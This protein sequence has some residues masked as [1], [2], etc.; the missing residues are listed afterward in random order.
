MMLLPLLHMQDVVH[1]LLYHAVAV[2]AA[3][4]RL[5]TAQHLFFL[6]LWGLSCEGGASTVSHL[7]QTQIFCLYSRNRS[8]QLDIKEC[9]KKF[10]SSRLHHIFFKCPWKLYLCVN[11][12]WSGWPCTGSV[13]CAVV[14]QPKSVLRRHFEVYMIICLQIIIK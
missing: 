14:F 5:L 6:I 8:R 1:V 9:L 7:S 13:V 2:S 12:C 4:L 3:V 10:V 11:V